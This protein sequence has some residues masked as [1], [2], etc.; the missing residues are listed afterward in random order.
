MI[1]IIGTQTEFV[2]LMC[3]VAVQCDLLDPLLSSTSKMQKK[4][5]QLRMK[6]L[7]NL[8]KKRTVKQI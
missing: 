4:Y 8:Q 6:I 5:Q 2:V 7:L 3:D 1:M